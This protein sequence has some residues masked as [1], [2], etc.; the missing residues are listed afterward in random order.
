MTSA[1]KAA[2]KNQE[3]KIEKPAGK[4]RGKVGE[5]TRAQETVKDMR[6][7]SVKC[8]YGLK[9]GGPVDDDCPNVS[10]HPRKDNGHHDQT[11][12][13]VVSATRAALA[14]PSAAT[15]YRVPGAFGRVGQL[16]KVSSG[17]ARYVFVLK[18]T[19][20]DEQP[21]EQMSNRSYLLR[22]SEIYKRQL[23]ELQGHYVPVRLGYFGLYNPVPGTASITNP[24]QPHALDCSYFLALSY[25]GEP[26][27]QAGPDAITQAADNAEDLIGAAGVSRYYKKK[28]HALVH[29]DTGDV[30]V[31][32]FDDSKLRIP[33]GPCEDWYFFFPK[34]TPEWRRD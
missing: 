7:C 21:H 34:N 6:Y 4:Y 18:A 24:L 30:V 12:R 8:L 22:E 27:R 13:Q 26:Y 25:G 2:P 31:V 15:M 3:K 33:V 16:L 29:P 32:D 5:T 11:A 19:C 28:E 23:Q 20:D 9:N 14:P 10:H 17:E 1:K